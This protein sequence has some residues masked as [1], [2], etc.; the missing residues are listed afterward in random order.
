MVL[1]VTKYIREEDIAGEI[2]KVGRELGPE[3]VRYR[4][5][6]TYD[7]AGEPAI[8]FRIVLAD[9]AT[10]TNNLGPTAERVRSAFWD[11][12]D[13]RRNWG[14]N[15]YFSFRSESDPGAEPEWN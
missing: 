11:G 14:L 9:W 8:Y 4:Y 7:T 10:D 5:S 3:V 13:P 1:P 15:P 2:D 6:L 12:L